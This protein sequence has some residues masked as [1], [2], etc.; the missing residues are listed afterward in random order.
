MSSHIDLSCPDCRRPVGKN[1]V[2][3]VNVPCGLS[4]EEHKRVAKAREEAKK[5]ARELMV[6]SRIDEQLP[7]AVIDEIYKDAER[8]ARKR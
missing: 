5:Q 3:Y 4:A 2:G 6:Q 8:R 1:I 7:R